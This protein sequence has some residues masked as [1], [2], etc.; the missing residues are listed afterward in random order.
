MYGV[1]LSFSRWIYNPGFCSFIMVSVARVSW[2]SVICSFSFF[3][4]SV[5]FTSSLAYVAEI[6]YISVVKTGVAS[7]AISSA[8]MVCSVVSTSPERGAPSCLRSLL[9]LA[10][11]FQ[12]V[13]GGDPPSSVRGLAA[14]EYTLTT[15]MATSLCGKVCIGT[16]CLTANILSVASCISSCC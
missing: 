3:V 1:F 15:N 12:P 10:G 6:T 13:G 8:P 5:D 9:R 4:V 7:V 14:P 11:W 16:H 2:A